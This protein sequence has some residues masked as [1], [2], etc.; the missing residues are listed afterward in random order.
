MRGRPIFDRKGNSVAVLSI[1]AP[2]FRMPPKIQKEMGTLVQNAVRRIFPGEQSN[3]RVMAP[4][5]KE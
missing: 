5:R 2:R 4:M 1:S 3:L